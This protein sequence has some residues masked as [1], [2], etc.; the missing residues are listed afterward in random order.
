MQVPRNFHRLLDD[1]VILRKP[2][3][4]RRLKNLKKLAE[5]VGALKYR[6]NCLEREAVK[7]RSQIQ[8]QGASETIRRQAEEI[9]ALEFRI[10]TLLRSK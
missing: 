5:E 3:N 7:L 1:I 2:V 10:K 6:V 4:A 9:R 8:Q